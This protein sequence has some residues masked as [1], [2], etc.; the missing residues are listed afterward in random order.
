M[1]KFVQKTTIAE[2]MHHAAN[3]PGAVHTTALPRASVHL[4]SPPPYLPWH[5]TRCTVRKHGLACMKGVGIEHVPTRVTCQAW[6]TTSCP[7]FN[8]PS[9]QARSRQ[10]QEGP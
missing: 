4:S 2:V 1:G 7:W 10:P 3:M 6:E 5:C 8:E 9:G